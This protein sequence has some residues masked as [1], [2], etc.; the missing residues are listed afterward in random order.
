MFIAL[1]I[2][3]T[4]NIRFLTFA[5]LIADNKQERRR[6]VARQS[7]VSKLLVISGGDGYEVFDPPQQSK[8]VGE[9]DC[10]NHLLRSEEHTSELQSHSDLVCRLLLEKK[11][12]NTNQ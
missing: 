4:G 11:K 5:E 2:G 12:Q 8:D 6:S 9:H 1:N 10:I 7:L 3:H